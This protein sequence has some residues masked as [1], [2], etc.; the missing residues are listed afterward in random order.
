MAEHMP[1]LNT[2]VLAKYMSL[3][4]GTRI[5]AEYVWIGG[6][7]QDL[8]SKTMTLERVPTDVSELRIWNFDGS[9]TGQ[10]SRRAGGGAPAPAPACSSRTM[11]LSRRKQE[12]QA[13]PQPTFPPSV[14]VARSL[15]FCRRPA[16]TARCC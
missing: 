6:S 12:P 10:V 3:P 1:Q 2:G 7:G 16:T 4:Q 9:S 15:A 8:R 13:H 14:P 5:Q 11:R